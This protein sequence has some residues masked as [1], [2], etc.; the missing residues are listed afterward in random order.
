MENPIVIGILENAAILIATAVLYDFIWLKTD[1]SRKLSLQALLGILLGGIGIILMKSP[2]TLVDGIVFDTRSILLTISGLFFGGI[3]TVIAMAIMIFYRFY[4][5]G[6]GAFMGI[7]VIATSALIGLVWRKLHP[8]IIK[9][10]KIGVIY[11]VSFLVHLVMLACTSF[12]PKES[13]IETLK[14]IWWPVLLVYPLATTLIAKLLFNREQNWHNKEKLTESEEKYRLLFENNP[15]PMWIYDLETLKFLEVNRAAIEHYGYTREEFLTMNLKD[16]RPDEDVPKLLE[17]IET[18]SDI[19]QNSGNWRHRKKNGEII[20]VQIASHSITYNGRPARHVMVNDVTELIESHQIISQKEKEFS[21]IFNSVFDS[22]QIND[23]DSGKIIDCND[24]TLQMYG[25]SKDEILNGN[26]GDLSA[27]IPPYDEDNAKRYIKKAIEGE[28]QDFEWLARKKNGETFW[29]NVRLKLVEIGG[30]NRVMAIVRDISD[31]KRTEQNFIESEQRFLRVMH[32]SK[33][34]IGILDENFHFI[35][36]NDSA[37][38]LHGF[39][40]RIELLKNSPHPSALSPQTQ[41][42]ASSSY[43]LANKM[44]EI[45]L[46]Q[47]FNKFEWLHNKVNGQKFWA[48]VSLTPI[49]FN[50]KRMIYAVWRDISDQKNKQN[51][52]DRLL[53]ILDESI[54]EVYIFR[55]D[56]LRFIEFN[57][58]ALSNVGYSTEELLELTP[59]DLKPYL[60]AEK[61]NELLKPLNDGTSSKIFFETIHRRKNGTEYPVE[62]YVEKT[63]ASDIDVYSAIVLDISQRKKYLLELE[64]REHEFTEIFNST[65]EAI[66]IYDFK[67]QTITDCNL[68]TQKLYGYSREELLG[69]PLGYLSSCKPPYSIEEA[70]KIVQKVI[71]EGP[72]TYLWQGKKKNGELFWIEISLKTATIAGEKRFIAVVRDVTERKA[73][74]EKIS[75]R[76]REFREIFNSTSEAIIIYNP[77]D[78]SIV[79][80]N[81]MAIK[82]YGYPSKHEF[83]KC[84]VS[85]LSANVEPYKN[86]RIGIYSKMAAEEGP[87]RFDWLAKRKNGEHFWIEVTLRRT[88][89]GGFERDLAVIRDITDRKK[90]EDDLVKAKEK[91]EESDRLKSAFLANLSHEIRTPMNAIMGFGDLLKYSQDEQKRKEYIDVIQKSG[92][93]LMDIINETVEIAKL[94]TGLIKTNPENFNLDQLMQDI[95]NELKIKISGSKELELIYLPP[96]TTSETYIYTDRVKLQQILI[97]LITNGIKYTPRG[98]VAYGYEIKDNFVVFNVKDTGIGIDRKNRE[99]VFK[100]FYRVE[101][102]LTIK[103]GGIGLGLAITKAYTELLGGS[104]KLDSELGKGTSVTVTLPFMTGEPKSEIFVEL[105]QEQLKGENE[106]I[107]VAEDDEYNFLYINEILREFN[108]KCIRAANGEEAVNIAHN[109]E[110]IKLILM[111]LKMPTMDGFKAFEEIRKL[112]PQ[113]PIVAQ[114]AYVLGED[115]TKIETY[116]FDGYLTKPL[117]KDELL[118][119]VNE[120][121]K[122]VIR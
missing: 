11:L 43:E 8:K 121:I 68:A 52:I 29:V 58:T 69:K 40:S 102:P 105:P 9:E 92:F 20:Y 113:I 26:I 31:R 66:L 112:K 5:G 101:N 110:N 73:Y 15:N 63:K 50:G 6:A 62:V 84:D 99:M 93:R 94:D 100:R 70:E 119:V 21:E 77:H 19:Y 95:Y 7:A 55:S 34:A 42:C 59:L 44:I 48:E 122:K 56:N 109:N 85:T 118:R 32:F 104:I 33:D 116:G 16:I 61:F 74:Q 64:K 12:L 80:C 10:K 45:A 97:N 1:K 46:E 41:P 39:K 23:I 3:T 98:A 38:R 60:T 35:D 14:V 30:V 2:W 24:I 114:T 25:Y 47:G 18:H 65:Q 67:S 4:L 57:K 120:R 72:Q 51:R 76:E 91:A 27:N 75:Q 78:N 36:C 28:S 54:N 71:A 89:I 79:D 103:V 86:E 13:R 106:L 108:Y 90:F 17:N 117:K 88:K 49:V 111:D 83:L 107:L 22:I 53:K 87:Q 81:D 115:K 96:N 37:A 82:M